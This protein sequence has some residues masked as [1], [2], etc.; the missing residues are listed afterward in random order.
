MRKFVFIEAF[1]A[2]ALLFAACQTEP[3]PV[4]GTEDE[5]VPE[6]VREAFYSRY[7]DAVEVS[8]TVSDGF[9]VAE[10]YLFSDR[11]LKSEDAG[12]SSPDIAWFDIL[13]GTWEMTRSGIEY[14]SLPQEVRNAFTDSRYSEAPWERSGKVDRLER[15]DV[16]SSV[17]ETSPV[18][19]YV[20]GVTGVLFSDFSPSQTVS[21]DLYFSQEGVLVDEI[22]GSDDGSYVDRL[23]QEPSNGIFSYLQE[24]VLSA[25]GR[26]I[27]VDREN[28]RTEVEAVLD[29]R[30]LEI[31]FDSS[32]NWLYTETGYHRRDIVSGYIPE[33]ILAALRSSE[34]FISYDY[35]DD[36]EYV[37]AS[38]PE[39]IRTWWVFEI[40]SGRNDFDVFVDDSGLI[41]K[42][43]VGS[44]DDTGGLPLGGEVLDFINAR[45][46]GARVLG[47]DYDDGFLEVDIFHDGNKKE[48]KFNA[49]GEWVSTVWEIRVSELPREVYDAVISGGYT[50]DD[51]EVEVLETPSVLCHVVDARSGRR[52]VVLYIG[53]DGMILS[54]RH[55]D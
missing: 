45:Y 14:V 25:G 35:I 46:P 19:V 10:F 42:P 37:R 52:E 44:G 13:D 29:G 54:V 40:D 15:R 9:A 50:F 6:V 11:A 28:G 49:G 32:E 22:T 1:A 16:M 7:P 12:V 24:N 47:S 4:P 2:A 3:G 21:V 41:N 48:L 5:I 53:D 33:N 26:V 31:F 17:S 20:I 36:I 30:R 34:H 27:E 8:W 18:V 55:D 39:G 23:P 38:F 43:A 51:N